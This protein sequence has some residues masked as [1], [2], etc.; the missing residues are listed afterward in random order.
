MHA[1]RRK[2]TDSNEILEIRNKYAPSTRKSKT[3][4]KSSSSHKSTE[5]KSSITITNSSGS[6]RNF[7]NK[8]NIQVSESV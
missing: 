4:H 6:V 5:S 3:N 2:E 7:L 8:E 1:S